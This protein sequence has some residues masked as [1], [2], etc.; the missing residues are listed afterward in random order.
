M[1]REERKNKTKVE[2]VKNKGLP[3]SFTDDRLT[4]LGSKLY[5]FLIFVFYSLKNN[6]RPF[7]YINVQ[8]CMNLNYQA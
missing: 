7:E 6:T 2:A 4:D 8:I 3:A 1:P 5:H